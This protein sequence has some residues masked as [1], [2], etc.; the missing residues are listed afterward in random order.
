LHP[1]DS[2]A[3]QALFENK[4]HSTIHSNQLYKYKEKFPSFNYYKYLKL[5]R[6]NYDE[7]KEAKANGYDVLSS[8]DL[9]EALDCLG[10]DSEILSQ[11]K[12]FLINNFVTPFN[13]I[14]HEMFTEN[15][16]GLFK[17]REA[18][19]YFMDILY[20][21]ID[22]LN[23]SIKFKS[24]SNV[25]GDAWTQLDIS[26]KAKV[27]GEKTEYLFWRI[28]KK[29]GDYYLRLSQ[30]AYISKDYKYVKKKT[31]KKLREFIEPLFTRYGLSTSPPSNRG[32][33]ESEICII[34]FKNNDLMNV[35]NVLVDLTKDVIKRY[36]LVGQQ[37]GHQST[38][39]NIP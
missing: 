26:H 24:G 37:T 15:N 12:K 20:Q 29:S 25:G 27:Y 8:L 21:E 30:Y 39:S 14:E 35:S 11:Y 10:L 32:V 28:D 33:K 3:H 7:K 13:E 38:F 17:K 1:I 9:Y 22:G 6:I 2:V 16:F 31:L 36:Q 34:Y 4:T 5:A 19:Q 18:Q 23:D